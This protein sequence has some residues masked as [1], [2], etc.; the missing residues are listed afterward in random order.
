MFCRGSLCCTLTL[1]QGSKVALESGLMPEL[2]KLL[3][4]RPADSIVAHTALTIRHLCMHDIGT[5]AFVL[6][7]LVP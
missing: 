3:H 5:L 6:V 4:A 2:V 7:D 1:P